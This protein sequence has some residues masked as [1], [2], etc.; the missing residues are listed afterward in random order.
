[1]DTQTPIEIQWI[2]SAYEFLLHLIGPVGLFLTGLLIAALG[3][4]SWIGIQLLTAKYKWADNLFMAIF[5]LIFFYVI[6]R[7]G[8]YEVLELQGK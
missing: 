4:Y 3:Y 6:G 5:V 2:S 7:V 1:M 8:Y